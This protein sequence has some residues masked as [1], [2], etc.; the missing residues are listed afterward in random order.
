M[1]RFCSA[2]MLKQEG[3]SLVIHQIKVA[4]SGRSNGWGAQEADVWVAQR[5]FSPIRHIYVY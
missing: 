1:N 2:E 3:N 4:K 5:V